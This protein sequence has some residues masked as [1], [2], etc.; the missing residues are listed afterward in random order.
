MREDRVVAPVPESEAVRLA[1]EVYGLEADA[2]AL[3]GEYDAN[4]HVTTGDGPG[5]VL[6]VMHPARE[7]GLV[8]LQC[9]ALQHLAERAPHLSAAPGPPPTRGDTSRRSAEVGGAARIVWMLTYVPG[10]VLAEA[11]PHSPE[12]LEASAGCWARWTPRSPTS[13]TRRRSAS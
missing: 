13:R 5:F 8:D 2:R 10:T 1:R 7:R 4:F 9:A 12:L 11:R 6:K 3:P